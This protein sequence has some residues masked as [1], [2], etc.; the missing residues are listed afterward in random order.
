MKRILLYNSGGGLGDSIQLFTLIL[1]LQKYYKNSEFFYLGA[2]ENHFIGKLKEFDIKVTTLE[3]GMK[4]FGFRWWHFFITKKRFLKQNFKT[5]DL[6]IDLQSKFRNTII[7]KKIPHF[8]FYS[9]TFAYKFCSNKG[10]YVSKDHLTNLNKFLNTQIEES[11]YE[12]NLLPKKYIKEAERL[13]PNNNYIGFSLTQGN[14][15]RK[16]SWA[17]ENFINVAKQI[18]NKNKTPVFF[19][20]KDKFSLIDRLKDEIPS[21]LF[22]ELNSK[23]SSPALVTALSTRLDKAISIDN[24]VMHMIGLAKIPMIVL[25][26]PTDSG[27]FSPRGESIN[28]LD[29][30]KIYNSDDIN[31]IKVED[32]LNLI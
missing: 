28:I 18:V 9:S 24:G 16:K 27:K 30:K 26:G 23:I 17:I 12:L 19:I 15:Y 29:S 31:T 14:V 32:V 1:S 6:I 13:L 10:Q 20:E 21:A 4:Y 25:F 7:L 11:N 5:F 22:P 3:L 2:H 8:N